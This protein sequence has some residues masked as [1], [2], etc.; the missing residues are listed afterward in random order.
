MDKKKKHQISFFFLQLR[1]MAAQEVNSP[2]TRE[3][4]VANICVIIIIRQVMRYA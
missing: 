3:I 1:G 4:I 2:D